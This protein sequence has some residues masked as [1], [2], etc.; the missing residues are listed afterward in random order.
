MRRAG[1]IS[2]VR[3]SIQRQARKARNHTTDAFT[4]NA[5]VSAA[6]TLPSP[7][8]R[9]RT[10]RDFM[11]IQSTWDAY[12]RSLVAV[13]LPACDGGA[14]QWCITGNEWAVRRRSSVKT[15][16]APAR[17]GKVRAYP[18]LRL[19]PRGESR[20]GLW[21]FLFGDEVDRGCPLR[22][23]SFCRCVGLRKLQRSPCSRDHGWA[24]LLNNLQQTAWLLSC[25]P[26]PGR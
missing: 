24:S 20:S 14:R 19:C 3:E 16:R 6:W 5:G 11:P 1:D 10:R 2:D 17:L 15:S 26:S 9:Y 13:R 7:V 22:T 4:G 21:G 8:N 18:G 25:L 12:L 23:K